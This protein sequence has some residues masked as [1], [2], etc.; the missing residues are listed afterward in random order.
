M[1]PYMGMFTIYPDATLGR[2]LTALVGE[3]K[4]I[5]TDILLSPFR[6]L[7]FSMMSSCYSI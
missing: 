4:G 6:P 3:L 2:I 5:V 1:V 7:F